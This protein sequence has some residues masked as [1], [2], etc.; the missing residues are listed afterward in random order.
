MKIGVDASRYNVKSGT[1]VELYSVK[2]IHGLIEHFKKESDHELVL[3]SPRKLMLFKARNIKHRVIPFKRLWTKVR[4]SIEML[5]HKPDVLFVPSHVLPHFS[6]K[7]SIITIHDVAF[8]HLRS[9]YSWFNFWYLKKETLCAVKKASTIIV[10]S[11]ATKRDLKHFFKCPDEKIRI[12]YHGHD[13]K[14]AHV[15]AEFENELFQRL[16][17][18]RS[19][20]FFLFIGRLEAKKN[21]Y[22]LMKAFRGFNEK[23]PHYKL[24]LAGSRG[25]GFNKMLK[26][27][28]KQGL[29][30]NVYMP[31]Y[32]TDKEKHVLLK[33]CN[34]FV[35]P[36]LYEGFGFPILE[37]YSYEKPVVTSRA[38]SIPEVAG[39]GAVYVNPHSIESIE[40][41]LVRVIRGEEMKDAQKKQLAK[42]KWEYAI[43]NTIELLLK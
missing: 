7:R 8:M 9:A 29:L 5:F 21:I 36:S 23:F 14:P 37:A 12:I 32:V 10:P 11:E 43:E 38:A 40:E 39:D 6:P 2:I 17:L 20:H 27:S 15:E 26:K 30:D 19:D 35:F 28:L 13:F 25:Q 16:G 34:A 18:K 4:L 33:Y 42:F 1:G 41:G 24:L 31:G 22:R 3:Y